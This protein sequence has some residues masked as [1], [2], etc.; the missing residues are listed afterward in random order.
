MFDLPKSPP[1]AD[2]LT[3]EAVRNQASENQPDGGSPIE[4]L[5]L[6]IPD[7]PDGPI[8]VIDPLDPEQSAAVLALV[9][10]E[11]LKSRGITAAGAAM[12]VGTTPNA[13]RRVLRGTTHI[14]AATAAARALGVTVEILSPCGCA[15]RMVV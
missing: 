2:R 12:I 10:S 8:A 15:G 4:Q 14:S 9:L 6:D 3:A 13:L 7:L 11:H 5:R 1:G